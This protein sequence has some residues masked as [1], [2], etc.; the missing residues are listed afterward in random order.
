MSERA[1]AARN[2]AAVLAAAHRLICELGQDTASMDQIA[3]AAGV[4]KGTLFRRFGDRAGLLT[5]LADQQI[6]A[7]QPIAI[8]RSYDESVDAGRRAIRFMADVCDM[9]LGQRPIMRALSHAA[10]GLAYCSA[11]STLWLNRL[12]ELIAESRPDLDAPYLAAS[13]FGILAPHLL[14]HLVDRAG[15]T[16]ARV[17]AGVISLTHAALTTS[18]NPSGD[19]VSEPMGAT[20]PE[21]PSAG[22]RGSRCESGAV[23]PL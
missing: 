17:R 5:A 18:G 15:M 13:L 21:Q 10:P 7:W 8:T 12:T 11:N 1:D 4:G 22:E 3:A 23:P 19:L 14:D 16:S 20:M 9:M 2:R 6:A